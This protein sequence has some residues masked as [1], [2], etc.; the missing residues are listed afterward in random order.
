[1]AKGEAIVGGV[2]AA[3]H[4]ADGWLSSTPNTP[5]SNCKSSNLASAP[6]RS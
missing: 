6:M 1:L 5:S 2:C 3:C 4:M